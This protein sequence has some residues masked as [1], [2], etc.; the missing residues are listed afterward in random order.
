MAFLTVKSELEKIRI[1]ICWEKE[2]CVSLQVCEKRPLP[3][4]SNLLFCRVIR[5]RITNNA[6]MVAEGIQTE[7]KKFSYNKYM[8]MGK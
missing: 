7:Y 5:G 3:F 4:L 2:V 6:H 1:R 8:I